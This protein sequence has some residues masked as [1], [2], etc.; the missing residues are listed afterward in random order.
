[1]PILVYPLYMHARKI[2]LW[3]GSNN[4][5][6]MIRTNPTDIVESWISERLQSFL[7]F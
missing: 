5:V 3:L 6:A 7:M 2:Q 1:M 4:V